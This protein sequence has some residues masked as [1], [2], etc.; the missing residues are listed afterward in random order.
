MLLLPLLLAGC[1]GTP[2]SAP[3]EPVPFPPPPEPARYFYER[4]VFG[5]GDVQGSSDEDRLRVLLT[6]SS[7]KAGTLFAKP[8]DVAVHRGRVFVS[9]TV[10]NAVFALDFPT[11]HT[12]LIGKQGDAGDLG[13]PLGIAVDGAGNLYVVDNGLKRV[14]VYDRDGRFRGAFGGRDVLDRPTG[15]AVSR[16]GSRAYV[17]D[18]GG[19]RSENHTVHVFDPR[20]GRLLHAI[21]SRGKGPGELN[22]PRDVALGPDGLLYV[23]DGGNFRVQ[24]FTPE[25]RFVRAWGEPGM[26]YGQFSRPKG[27]ATDTEGKVYVV[28]AA[29]GNFQIFG[30]EGR[31]LLFIGRR[32]ERNGPGVFMLPAGVDVDEDGRVYVIDQYYRKLEILRPAGLPADKGTLVA[33]PPAR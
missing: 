17:V 31:L 8:F 30:A 33:P 22:L 2:P 20:D 14:A 5:T 9:D 24:V 32:S 12:F 21:G 25:G 1:A 13:K 15:I 3:Q 23:S 26:R 27:I 6:G 7:G 10:L 28:D 16:D 4:S 19:V 11:H 18:V 29:F